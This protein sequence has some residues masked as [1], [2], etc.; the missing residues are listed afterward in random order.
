[1]AHVG[2]QTGAHDFENIAE[3]M[4]YIERQTSGSQK[5]LYELYSEL[6]KGVYIG[7]YIGTTIGVIKGY[8]RSSDNG[9]YG[10]FLK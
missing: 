9:S 10:S 8:T 6:L 4:Q 5:N 2:L 7:E 3:L 1:M